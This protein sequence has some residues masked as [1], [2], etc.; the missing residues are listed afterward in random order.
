MKPVSVVIKSREF[1]TTVVNQDGKEN[2]VKTVPFILSIIFLIFWK[3]NLLLHC[4]IFRKEKF[5]YFLIL[6]VV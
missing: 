6:I 4:R 2:I 1:V 3:K 5:Y